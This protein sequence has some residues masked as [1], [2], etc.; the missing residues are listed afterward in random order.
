MN[1]FS[2][3]KTFKQ[4]FVTFSKSKPGCR[5]LIYGIDF[6]PIFCPKVVQ[7]LD[8]QCY[9]KHVFIWFSFHT[10]IRV[11]IKVWKAKTDANR[12]KIKIRYEHP[13]LSLSPSLSLPHT[14]SHTHSFNQSLFALRKPKHQ[15]INNSE[16]NVTKRKKKLHPIEKKKKT[17]FWYQILFT[18]CHL[19]SHLETCIFGE[20]NRAPLPN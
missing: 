8:Y 18:K 5:P 4:A 12:K 19:E 17:F 3:A 20:W 9:Y 1:S 15:N 14:H 6:W 11:G 13:S 10:S 16:K 2:E 7:L